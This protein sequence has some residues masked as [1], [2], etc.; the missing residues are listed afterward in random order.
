MD[1]SKIKTRALLQLF[2]EAFNSE[3]IKIMLNYYNLFN[4]KYL[5]ILTS[6]IFHNYNILIKNVKV[7]L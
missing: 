6:K 2:S 7:L 4:P 1:Y 5:N 3:N